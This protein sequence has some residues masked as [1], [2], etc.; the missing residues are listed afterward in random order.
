[1]S[2]ANH[3]APPKRSR[4][5]VWPRGVWAL[6]TS[7]QRLL[8]QFSASGKPTVGPG[9]ELFLAYGMQ[10][11]LDPFPGRVNSVLEVD[12]KQ[13]NSFLASQWDSPRLV[14]YRLHCV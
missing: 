6:D 4:P 2:Q 11:N 14:K 3:P 10:P 7:L 13:P 5:Q 8:M 1:M 9:S 12:L